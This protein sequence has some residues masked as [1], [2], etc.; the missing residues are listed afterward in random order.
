[1]LQYPGRETLGTLRVLSS[2]YRVRQRKNP[3]MSTF[4]QITLTTL[5]V[6]PYLMILVIAILVFGAIVI[7]LLAAFG[8]KS[9]ESKNTKKGDFFG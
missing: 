1:M 7:R 5:Y 4:D 6:F 8:A 9:S 3:P 2:S